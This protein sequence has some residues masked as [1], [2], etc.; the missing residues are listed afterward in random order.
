VK[1]I[2][3]LGLLL[4]GCG[5]QAAGPIPTPIGI[6]ARFHP[7]PTNALV[8]AQA[9]IRGLRCKPETGSRYGVHVELFADGL[10]VIV[11]PGIGVA[12]PFRRS[13]AFVTPRGCTYP[14]RTLDPT[15]VIEVR[16]VRT[17]TLG[18]LFAVW[19][20]PLSP[21]RLA[22]FRTTASRPVRAYVGGKEWRGSPA[23]I[24]L[25]RHAEIVLELGPFIPP[26]R[27]F[28]FRPGL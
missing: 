1:A 13:G 17:L 6:G 9:P 3:A 21:T 11:P 7:G 26:H 22:R 25:R 20:V 15:G 10:V 28:L 4:A 16:P 5:S 2:L 18:D 27:S 8:Q 23:A 14:L 12:P 24:P 19:G